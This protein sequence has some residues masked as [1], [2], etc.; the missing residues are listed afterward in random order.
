MLDIGLPPR[1]SDQSV[2]NTRPA[3]M[4]AI[5]FLQTTSHAEYLSAGPHYLVHDLHTVVSF[6]VLS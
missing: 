5:Q 6:R 3:Q 4:S 1:N 2:Q